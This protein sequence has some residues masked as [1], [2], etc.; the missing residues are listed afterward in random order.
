MITARTAMQRE[1]HTATKAAV[2]HGGMFT[3]P[4]VRAAVQKSNIK[5]DEVTAATTLFI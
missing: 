4:F 2:L 5:C 3:R 1:N